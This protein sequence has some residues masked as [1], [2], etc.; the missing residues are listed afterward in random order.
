MLDI[1]DFSL[2]VAGIYDASMNIERWSDTLA[3]FA[4]IF[5]GTAAQISVTASWRDIASLKRQ[6][7]AFV[8]IWGIPDDVLARMM[9]RYI[10]LTPTDPRMHMVNARYK[11]T[12]CREL[13]SDEVLWASEMY[14]QVLNPYGVEYTMGITIPVDEEVVAIL[15][16]MRGPRVAPFTGDECA[17]FSRFAPH[18]TRAISMYGAFRRCREELTSV[19]ALLD[20]VPLGMLVVEDDELK[21]ANRA[22]RTMLDEGDAM[23]LQNGRLGGATRRADTDLR[24]AVHEALDGDDRAV[25]VTLPIDHA[26]PVRAVVRRL[27]PGSAKMVGARSEAV[28][29]YVTDPRKPLETSEETLQR[30]FGLTPREA[31]VLRMLVEGDDLQA[32]ASRLG[33]TIET[34]RSHV[35]HIM[36]TTGASRQA[37]LVRM[38]LSSPAWVS[39]GK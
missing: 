23:R 5:G 15:S 9:P 35:K 16:V 12:H 27:H 36:D 29:L 20:G 3:H 2:A 6:D 14:K 8:K 19:K 31:L 38:V 18:V 11:A 32:V 24:A 30:L 10:A 34:V 1:D 26:E 39:G 22:A 4:K 7:V 17:D 21:V 28:A 13:V 25:G 33:I 37:E